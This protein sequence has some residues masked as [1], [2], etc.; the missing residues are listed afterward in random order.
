MGYGKDEPWEKRSN[1]KQ[2]AFNKE[3]NARAEVF[4]SETFCPAVKAGLSQEI[5]CEANVY[6]D[7]RINRRSF[8]PIRTFYKYG[9]LTGDPFRDWCAGSVDSCKTAQIEPYAAKYYPKI[10]EQKETAILTVAPERTFWEKPQSCTMKRTD[11]NIWKCRSGIP[12]I[13]MISTAWLQHRSKKL[14]FQA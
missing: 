12:D 7:E 6:I 14:L 1:T 11:R 4:L 3:A 5:G 2:D 8:S 10:F 9:D 13:I